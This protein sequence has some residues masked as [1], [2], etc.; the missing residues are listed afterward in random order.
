MEQWEGLSGCAT[1]K[2]SAISKTSRISQK[3]SPHATLIPPHIFVE[4][5]LDFFDL[6]SR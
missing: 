5:T 2:S 6:N 3:I 4:M 1:E